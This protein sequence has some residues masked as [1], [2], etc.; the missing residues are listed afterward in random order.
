MMPVFL[1][2]CWGEPTLPKPT[3]YLSDTANILTPDVRQQLEILLTEVERQTTS[4]IAVVTI[5]SLEGD[6]LER[7]TNEL[8]AKWGVGKKGKDNGV[9]ILLAVHDRK[10]RIE[11]GYGVEGILPDGL[12]G[13]IIRTRMAPHLKE[14]RF[15]QGVVEGVSAVASVLR[16]DPSA[17]RWPSPPQ[18]STSSG[19]ALWIDLGV[20]AL[21]MLVG[22]ATEAF[23]AL[24][25]KNRPRTGLMWLL[26]ILLHHHGSSRGGGGWS[27]GGFSGGGGGF[28]GFGGGRSGGGGASGG[29]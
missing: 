1:T 3:G 28:G 12:C 27:S 26:W 7:Y 9:M 20:I 8:F 11:T 22:A 2:V 24:G 5:T 18:P 21:I 10:V 6:S 19:R 17:P 14:G 4:E 25:P 15:A 23:N 13:E 16:R 29:W